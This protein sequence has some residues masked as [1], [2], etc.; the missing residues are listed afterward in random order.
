MKKKFTF[1]LLMITVII[2]AFSLSACFGNSSQNTE[3]QHHLKYAEGK[4]STCVSE[5][6]IAYYYCPDCGKMFADKEGKEEITSVKTPVGEHCWGEPEVIKNANCTEPGEEKYTCTLCHKEKTEK[7]DALGHDLTLH[8]GLENDCIHPGQTDYFTCSRCGKFYVDETAL[9]ETTFLDSF[10]SP[11]GHSFGDWSVTKNATCT[12]SGEKTRVCSCGYT[13][14]EPVFATGHKITGEKCDLCSADFTDGLAFELSASGTEYYCMGWNYDPSTDVSGTEIDL[15]IPAT[16]EGLPVTAIKCGIYPFENDTRIKSVTVPGSV[17]T[18]YAQAFRNCTGLE[19]LFI[20]EG[21]RNISYYAFHNCNSLKY[22]SLPSSLSS[23]DTYA[24]DACSSLTTVVVPTSAMNY[25]QTEKLET[26]KFISGTTVPSLENCTSL[27]KLIVSDSVQYINT[28]AFSQCS[29]LELSEY[30]NAYYLGNENNRYSVLVRAV[31]KDVEVC[32]VHPDTK[33]IAYSAF[34]NCADLILVNVS[35]DSNISRIGESAFKGCT[36]LTNIAIY[37][38]YTSINNSVFEGCTSL[39]SVYLPE[40]ITSVG[41]NAFKD[42]VSLKEVSL[43]EKVTSVG[44]NAFLNCINLQTLKIPSVTS[45]GANAFSGC[46]NIKILAMHMKAY[47][48]L[49]YENLE[50]LTI[51]G[52][53]IDK[54]F[55]YKTTINKLTVCGDVK[56]IC[57]S[58][59]ESCY[60]ESIILEDGVEKLNFAAFRGNSITT[61]YLPASIKFIDSV[62]FENCYKLTEIIVDPENDNY[63]SVDGILYSKDMTDLLAYPASKEGTSYTVPETVDNIWASAFAG[64]KYLSEINIGENVKNIANNAFS[65]CESLKSV[66]IPESIT[67]IYSYLFSYNS[68]IESV[69]LPSG[70]TEIGSSI[71]DDAYSMK[72]IYFKGTTEQWNNIVISEY[73]NEELYDIPVYCYSET[74]PSTAG[75]YWHFAD[76]GVTP[77]IW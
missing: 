73:G 19:S 45:I 75:N 6:N 18:I 2:C 53:N 60:I 58:A 42:C 21:V 38:T 67:Y 1:A 20:C 25:I 29:L 26:I 12:E 37:G 51:T 69:I 34:E 46:T 59:F 39:E 70:L 13:E 62:V 71:F 27:K 56:E 48:Y 44:E 11:N 17:T 23:V 43:S 64:N 49:T 30:G 57:N 41:D 72:A 33:V 7:T 4:P 3:H 54:P 66:T 47:D 31:S 14:T 32:F 68:V 55:S 77:V 15:I 65:L 24:F 9:T 36:S 28:G 10:T 5:G 50:D 74:E 76:D 8:N 52:G 61:I 40:T 35:A 63:M 22:L 16:Y